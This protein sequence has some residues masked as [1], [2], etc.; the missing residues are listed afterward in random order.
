MKRKQLTRILI[1]LFWGLLWGCKPVKFVPKDKYLLHKNIVSGDVK[2]V[3]KDELR[4]FI[5]PKENK[6]VFGFWHFHL[7]MYN[8]S[9]RDSSKGFN[10]WLRRIGEA[11]VVYD[12]LLKNKSRDQLQQFLVNKGYF[13]AT[14]SDTVIINQKKRKADV[15]YNINPGKRYYIHHLGYKIPDENIRSLVYSDSIHSLLRGKKPFDIDLYD[16]E[17]IRVT[18]LLNQNGYY[19]FSKEYIYYDVDSIEGTYTIL[20]TMVIANV[21]TKL[22]DGRDT[23]MNH[24]KY[25]IKDVYFYVDFD[26]QEALVEENKYLNKFDTLYY[27]GFYFLYKDKMK[28]KP[29]VL[30]NSNYI[31][32]GKLYDISQVAKTQTLITELKL[33]RYINI[34]FKELE[35]QTDLF[36]NKLMDCLIQLTPS[37]PQSY[38]LAIEGTN[39]SGNLGAA[40]NIKYQHRNL[41]KGAEIFNVRM[42]LSFQNQSAQGNKS[43]FNI[44]EVGF[45]AGLTFPKFLVPFK[46]E[47]F[48]K[49]Y[50]PRSSISMGV[51]YQRRPDYIRTIANAGLGYE[52]KSSEHISHLFS[53]L[54]F[55]LVFVPYI[56]DDFW[57]YIE[58]TF[59]QSSY[60]NHLILSANYTF[61][62]NG[63]M[64]RKKKNFWFFRSYLESSG[65][66][67]DGLANLF[68][69]GE[70]EEGYYKIFGI[71]YAQYVKGSFDVRYHHFKNKANS[72]AYRFFLGVGYP[73]GNLMVLP[74][75][76]MYFSGGANSIRAW[77]VRGLGPG[78]YK[79]E[80]L[81]YYNQTADIKLEINAEY[82]FKIF[83]KLEGALFVDMGNIWSIREESSPEGGLFKF[84]S[85][86]RQIAIGL[87]PGLR[88]DFSYFVFRFDVGV[89]CVDPSMP[90]GERWVLGT[91]PLTWD[92]FGFNFAIGYP[93]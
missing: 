18:K 57:D 89:K 26:P 74:F 87:G 65:N 72:F 79:E 80:D 47:S 11:P 70:P 55:N 76:K 49:K 4:S 8:L 64:L 67:L 54:D 82:R 61:T 14:V 51:N 73:Y 6:T 10:K 40:G 20:D 60:E 69:K 30:I 5:R 35:G 24:V 85:F 17:R 43:N 53:I 33:F 56:S 41:F 86:Y 45:E 25:R 52:W 62:Y 46:I 39:S 58:G 81:E 93:F 71:R 92:D 37:K 77:P 90:Q 91:N 36:D 84:N 23:V 16:K 32:P 38:A 88:V 44:L 34:K 83:W 27:K 42:R 66:L 3:S 75:E 59:M 29:D 1:F 31:L 22:P 63:Q 21:A 13:N 2:G 48:R 19:N 50:N 9:G 78:T 12:S 28:F 15:L 68:T 7:G